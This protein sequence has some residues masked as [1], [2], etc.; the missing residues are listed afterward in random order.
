MHAG[1]VLVRVPPGVSPGTVSVMTIT[2]LNASVDVNLVADAGV[3]V[4]ATTW[5]AIKA[6]YAEE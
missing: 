4:N 6:L 5:G 2:G 3:P 1:N